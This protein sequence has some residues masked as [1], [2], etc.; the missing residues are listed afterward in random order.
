MLKSNETEQMVKRLQADLKIIAAELSI[1]K[2]SENAL[3]IKE[4][5]D[6]KAAIVLKR[7][8]FEGFNILNELSSEVGQGFPEHEAYVVFKNDCSLAQIAK[9]VKASAAIGCSSMK[10]CQVSTAP[11]AADAVDANLVAELANDARLGAVGR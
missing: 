6:A 4:G 10:I 9:I 5:A 2:P 3:V 11:S 8:T 7:R 1:E